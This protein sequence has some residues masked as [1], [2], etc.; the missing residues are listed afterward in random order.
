LWR[1]KREKAEQR[2]SLLDEVRRQCLLEGMRR[3]ARRAG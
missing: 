3:F 2:K 1:A